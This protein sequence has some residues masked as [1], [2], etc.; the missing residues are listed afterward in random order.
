MST[1]IADV[2]VDRFRTVIAQ[3]YEF[4]FLQSRVSLP[5]SVTRDWVHA[6]R[7]YFLT[8]IFP[9]SKKRHQ[10]EAAFASLRQYLGSP[11]KMLPLTGDM[12][13]AIFKFGPQFGRA[14]KTAFHGLRAFQR[15]KGF[16]QTL[17]AYAEKQRLDNNFDEKQFRALLQAVPEEEARNFVVNMR[18]LLEAFL[19]EKLMSKGEDILRHI[20]EKMQS[21]PEIYPAEDVAAIEM[22]LDIIAEGQKLFLAQPEDVREKAVEVILENEN[23]FLDEL[24]NSR[25][26]S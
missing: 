19:D 3:R 13:K 14:M 11:K 26:R 21:R 23:L 8:Y 12:F 1:P 17:V 15:A 7:D 4:D 10:L 18:A 2:V 24:Y 9:E 25:G 20:Y 6:M 5:A 22:G 16:E